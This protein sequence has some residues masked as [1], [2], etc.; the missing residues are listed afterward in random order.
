MLAGER[1]PHKLAKLRARRIKASEETIMK[2]LVGEHLY[3]LRQ[4]LE[5]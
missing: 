5:C 1:D 2:S 3:V 4:S